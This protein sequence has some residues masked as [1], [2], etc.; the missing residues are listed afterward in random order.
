[1]FHGNSALIGSGFPCLYFSINAN[2]QRGAVCILLFPMVQ[3]L[4]VPQCFCL[5]DSQHINPLL[6]YA[7]RSRIATRAEKGIVGVPCIAGF[8]LAGFVIKHRVACAANASRFSV[9]KLCGIVR[10]NE[11]SSMN[12]CFG[13]RCV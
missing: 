2:P 3:D 5:F 9:L 10:A 1:M 7:R 13:F 11:T 4:P 8:L 12:E 6:R